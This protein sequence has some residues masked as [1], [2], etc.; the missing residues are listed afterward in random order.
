M[1]QILISLIDSF[2]QHAL[3]ITGIA[4]QVA[5]LKAIL[6]KYH[7]EMQ[8]D[9]KAQLAVENEGSRTYAAH[10]LAE[11]AQLRAAASRLS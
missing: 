1:Q 4:D 7:P 11:L 2:G 5:A 6:L 3:A 9:F 10:V 8:D